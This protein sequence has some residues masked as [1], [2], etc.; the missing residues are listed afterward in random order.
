M[1]QELTQERLKECLSYNPATGL[2]TWLVQRGP[3]R[4]GDTASAKDRDGYVTIRLDGR[5]YFAHRLAWFYMTGEW[6]AADIDHRE[7]DPDDNRWDSLRECSRSQNM[8]NTRR[9]C[10]NTSGVKGVY[11]CKQ[12]RKWRVRIKQ[13][14]K[15]V[16]LGM[17]DDISDAAQAYLRAAEAIFGE[18][19]RT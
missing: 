5:N 2:F 19:A 9:R 14:Y 3:R 1:A 10:T 8:A 4:P 15:Y 17:F 11:W 16:H 7:L 12:Q 18:F 6:P 13:N